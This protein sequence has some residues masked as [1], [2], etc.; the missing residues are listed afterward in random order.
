MDLKALNLY[1]QQERENTKIPIEV[2]NDSMRKKIISNWKNARLLDVNLHQGTSATPTTAP[3][4]INKFADELKICLEKH[5]KDPLNILEIM[6]GNCTA[7]ILV[8]NILSQLPNLTRWVA[9]D[10]EDWRNKQIKDIFNFNPQKF[11][12][13]QEN[14]V[15]A[16]ARMMDKTHSYGTMPNLLLMISPPPSDEKQLDQT[17]SYCDY[18][19]CKDY[20]TASIT[21]KRPNNCIALFGEIGA[22]DGSS[23][24]YNWLTTNPNLKLLTRKILFSK[25]DIFGGNMNKEIFVY[26]IIIPVSALVTAGPVSAASAAD[27]LKPCNVCKKLTIK[28]CA[29]CKLAYYCSRECQ[30]AD[31]KIHKLTCKSTSKSKYKYLKYKTKYNN[32]KN[33][34][35]F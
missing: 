6:S 7:S 22:S 19:S 25:K 21:N 9:T 20:I 12:F 28:K 30:E 26:S 24:M 3:D 15:D 13:I 33:A 5:I 2:V 35:I 16:I 14:G 1:L 32:L 11:N 31:W 18:Y 17:T 8:Y 10:I 34:N 27:E 29:G 4:I 23:G